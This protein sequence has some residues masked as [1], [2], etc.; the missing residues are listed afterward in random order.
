MKTKTPNAALVWKQF[1]DLLAPRLHLSPTERAVYSHL[2]RHTRLEGKSSLRFSM[3]WLARNLCLG[4]N[5]VRRALR[6]LVR[7]GVLKLL[8][9]SKAGHVVQV[10]LPGEIRGARPDKTQVDSHASLP[11]RANLEEIDFAKTPALRDAIHARDGGACFYCLRR[12]NNRNRCLDHVV[13][14]AQ[15]EFNSYRNLV[16]CCVECNSSKGE[17]PAPDFL[18]WL[19]RQG[20]LTPAELSE[21]LRALKRLA[22][23]KLRPILAR[24]AVVIRKQR[25]S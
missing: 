20:R 11:R 18:R 7:K 2:F 19:Y 17:R 4:Q 6:R 25:E 1:E 12:V 5:S 8:E 14:Q 15:R 21:G 16:S 23:G 9:R 24:P 10:R 22:A 3:R 13:P